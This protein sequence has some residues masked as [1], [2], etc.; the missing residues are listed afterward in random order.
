[1][2]EPRQEG[3]LPQLVRVRDKGGLEKGAGVR[4]REGRR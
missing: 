1:M 3:D 4:R 2:P